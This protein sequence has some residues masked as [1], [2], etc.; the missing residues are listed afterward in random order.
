MRQDL[1]PDLRDKRVLDLEDL[2]LGG[3]DLFFIFFERG[4]MYRS[5]LTERLLADIIPR[6]E[7]LVRFG[8]LD[9]IPEDWL[10]P[11]F[12]ELI[13]VRLISSSWNF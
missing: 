6:R 4:V 10:N 5:P 11:T 12:S 13:P 8:D 3:E 1:L 2:L 9:V 7:M